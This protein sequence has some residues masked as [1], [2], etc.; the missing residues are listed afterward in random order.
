MSTEYTEYTEYT[1]VI[2]TT[3]R[4]SLHD[5]LAAVVDGTGPA[6][7]EVI[8]VDDRKAPARDLAVPAGVRTVRSGG[9][10]PAAARNTG[11]R[12]ADT[13]WVAFLDDDVLPPRDWRAKVH[14]DLKDLPPDVAASQAR[15]TVPLPR[16]REPTDWERNTAGLMTAY[17]ITADMAY[18]I[19]RAHV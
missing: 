12:S 13:E 14:D 17:W 5:V 19:G 8:V 11:W 9:R 18:Q 1:V 7:R 6:P 3:G 15:I 2:P 10:G 16:G 4:D